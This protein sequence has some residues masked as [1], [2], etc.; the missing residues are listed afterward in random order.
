MALIPDYMGCS[1]SISYVPGTL[2]SSDVTSLLCLPILILI[3]LT[4]LTVT[5]ATQMDGP[6]PVCT[7][8]TDK[9]LEE[10]ASWKTTNV[11]LRH[12][13]RKRGEYKPGAWQ[14]KLIKLSIILGSQ[15]LIPNSR[16]D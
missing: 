7:V 15:M 11:Q 16:D 1:L 13:S 14:E 8:M 3:P 12:V 2:L 9:A 4:S 6:N 5:P 10:I